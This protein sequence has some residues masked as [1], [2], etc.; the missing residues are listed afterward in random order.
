MKT[1][2]VIGAALL[3]TLGSAVAGTLMYGSGARG[4]EP[5]GEPVVSSARAET[6]AM[7]DATPAHADYVAPRLPI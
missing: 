1:R 3:L 7:F 4:N 5:A 6:I 2:I